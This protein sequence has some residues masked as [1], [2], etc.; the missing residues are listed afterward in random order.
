MKDDNTLVPKAKP[1]TKRIKLIRRRQII[2]RKVPTPETQTSLRPV[3][4]NFA[5]DSVQTA[6]NSEWDEG[7]CKRKTLYLLSHLF[8]QTG[9]GHYT[10]LMAL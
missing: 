1:S 8:H 3:Q 7:L 6:K 10:Y 4:D 2:R 5:R 9:Y